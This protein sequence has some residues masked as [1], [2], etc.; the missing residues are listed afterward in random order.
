MNDRIYNY[1]NDHQYFSPNQNGFM[2]GKR[3]DDNVF[4][5]H[6]IHQ[7]Y[8][9]QNGKKVYVA[10]IDFRKYFDSINRQ[11]LLYKLIK[12]GITGKMYNIIKAAYERPLYCIKTK[13]G[14]T[15]YFP[16]NTGVK[17]GCILSPLLS[18]IF[19]NDLHGCFDDQCDPVKVGNTKLNSLS[20]AD[21]L[22]LLSETKEGLQESLNRLSKYCKKWGLVVNK[23]KTKCLT[24]CK[25]NPKI[26][27]FT[28]ENEI[29]ENV[30]EFK[31]LGVIIHK[32]GKFSQAINMIKDRISKANRAIHMLKCILGHTNTVSIKLA[33]SLF[34]KQV[35]PIL[36]YGSS[37]WGIPDN[38]RHVQ[39]KPTNMMKTE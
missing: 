27:T 29:L 32:N 13:N 30:T 17:Q 36:L 31:Y 34:D 19:Q 18:N 10:F 9:K 11:S 37:L 20:W 8:V 5:I 12:A 4:I 26:P 7:K 38:N 15:E 24:M 21:D 14:L 16:A 23:S 3:T 1:L 35:E 39:I 2:K 22:V 33:L 6:T 25:G 28:F